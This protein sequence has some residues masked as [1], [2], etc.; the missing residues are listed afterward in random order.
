[1][2]DVPIDARARRQAA[3]VYRHFAAGRLSNDELE[4]SLPSSREWALD[5]IWFR[6]MWPF[7]DDFHEHRLS[8]PYRLTPEGR[9][10]VARIVLFLRGCHP[11]RWPRTTGL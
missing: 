7:Y 6:G 11:Y 3:E 4:A 2:S 1:M 10:Y 8:G 5:D 9:R